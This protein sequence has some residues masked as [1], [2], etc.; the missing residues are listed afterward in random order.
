MSKK[1]VYKE[2]LKRAIRNHEKRPSE[3][4]VKELQTGITKIIDETIEKAAEYTEHADR[5]TIKKEDVR[6]ALENISN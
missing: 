3:E 5:K 4:G 2:S 1:V 6:A